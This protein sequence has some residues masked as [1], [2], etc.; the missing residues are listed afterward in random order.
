[1]VF[2]LLSLQKK[3]FQEKPNSFLNVEFIGHKVHWIR[4]NSLIQL[5]SSLK[6]HPE[7]NLVSGCTSTDYHPQRIHLK[8]EVIIQI[9]WMKELHSFEI[10]ENHICVGG[11]ITIAQLKQHLHVAI[12]TMPG[13]K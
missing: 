2:K 8:K 11:G 9:D 7:A 5:S 3:L 1:M 6:K 13:I 12:K 4:P 10:Y